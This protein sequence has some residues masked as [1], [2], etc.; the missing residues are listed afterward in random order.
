M[1]YLAS[2]RATDGDTGLIGIAYG[3]QFGKEPKFDLIA[4]MTWA[5]EC[6]PIT[7]PTGVK[8]PLWSHSPLADAVT[9]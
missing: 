7:G 2:W 1:E 6:D 3:F 4:W 8:Y 5:V 9:P